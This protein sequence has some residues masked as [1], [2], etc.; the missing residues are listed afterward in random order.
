MPSR[1]VLISF[2]VILALA[3]ITEACAMLMRMPI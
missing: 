2:W 1:A 3:M